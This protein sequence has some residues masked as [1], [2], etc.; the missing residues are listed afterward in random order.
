MSIDIGWVNIE[1]TVIAFNFRGKWTAEDLYLGVDDFSQIVAAK[2]YPVHMIIDLS[3]SITPPPNL[4]TLLRA[5]LRKF[6]SNIEQAVIISKSN[7]WP[8]VFLMLDSADLVPFP[9]QYVYNADDAYELLEA[10]IN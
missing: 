9:F 7:Y 2:P 4:L 1:E 6:P 8:R 10:H 5:A 3:Y